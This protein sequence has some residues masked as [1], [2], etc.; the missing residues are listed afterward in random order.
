MKKLILA[1]LAIVAI[2]G[3]SK[4]GNTDE[5]STVIEL[6]AGVNSTKSTKTPIN[7]WA[8]TPVS[9]AKGLTS[10]NYDAE[11]KAVVAASGIVTLSPIQTYDQQATFFL[12]GYTPQGTYAADMVTF[13][14]M[15][16]TQDILL[17]NEKSGSLAVKFSGDFAF[18][19][20]L[21]QLNFTVVGDATYG[22]G[23][24]LT[25]IV[26]NGTKL[27]VS[28]RLSNGE[29]TYATTT[30]TITSF[31]GTQPITTTATAPFGAVMVE[32][33]V[34]VTLTIEAG[35]KTYTDIPVSIADDPLPQAGTAYAIA[36]SITGDDKINLRAIV[37]PWLSG[38][39]EVVI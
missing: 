29:I 25:S 14:G 10:G 36:I 11:W 27:P 37:T 12:K 26:V 15:D 30:T 35:G 28:M 9:F 16:G 22:T 4:R 34:P 39:G 19:H 7:A 1:A 21:T 38:V 3:C 32:P 23:K 17:S 13:S 20:K 6:T 33:G 5:S 2:V 31:S 18:A 24:N 8:D